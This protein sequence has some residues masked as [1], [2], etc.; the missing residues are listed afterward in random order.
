[1]N[2]QRGFTLVE[3]L[4]SVAIISVLAGMSLP[5]YQSFNNRNELDIT[6]Q[7]LAN[8]LRR[9]Q[10]YSRGSQN[11]SPWGVEI[12]SGAITLF[13]GSVFAS[14]D[15]AYD[16]AIVVPAN[17]TISGDGEVLFAKLSGAPDATGSMTLTSI[18]NDIRTV[19]INAKGMVTY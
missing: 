3:V 2:R 16:E 6:T 17:V 12:Q 13:K 14:R 10:L 15:T 1:M 5:V 4:L 7:S 19:T 8:A 11:D 9:A 18:N